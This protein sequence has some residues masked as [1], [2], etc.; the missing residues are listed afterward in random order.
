MKHLIATTWLA[1]TTYVCLCCPCRRMKLDRLIVRRAADMTDEH[2][3][4]A[5]KAKL[6]R[7]I[8]VVS[9]CERVTEAGV[10]AAGAGSR[11][12]GGSKGSGVSVSLVPPLAGEYGD[13]SLSNSLEDIVFTMQT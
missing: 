5:A 4:S 6:A 8:V 12:I 13:A 9:D 7:E 2:L 1:S 11:G 3:L 10:V